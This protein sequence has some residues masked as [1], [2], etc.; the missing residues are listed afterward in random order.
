MPLPNFLIIGAAKSGTD[1]MYRCLRQHP[2]IYMC[3]VKEPRFFAF[4][5]SRPYFSGP[6]E[7]SFSA[8]IVTTLADY[9]RLFAAVTTQRAFGEAS[10]VYLTFGEPVARRIRDYVPQVKL[11]AILR[12]PAERAYLAYRM[13]L[14]KGHET[15]S[16]SQA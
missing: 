3:P 5:G 8:R 16:F 12:H 6:Q 14:A 10:P 1:A 9:L 7:A 4:E 2:E 15:L 13:W 11:I